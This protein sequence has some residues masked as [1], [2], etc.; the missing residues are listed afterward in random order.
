VN[1]LIKKLFDLRQYR[2]CKID[3]IEILD[4]YTKYM[5][6]II[7]VKYKEDYCIEDEEYE[8]SK[9]QTIVNNSIIK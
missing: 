3:N 5:T 6:D 9:I 4:F 7:M 1:D 2:R 8:G